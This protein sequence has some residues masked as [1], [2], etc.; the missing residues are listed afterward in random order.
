MVN[1]LD[2]DTAKSQ[3]FL[4]VF[5]WDVQVARYTSYSSVLTVSSVDYTSVPTM[6][7]DFIGFTAQPEADKVKIKI[8]ITFSPIDTLYLGNAHAIVSCEVYEINPEDLTSNRLLIQ[9]KITDL[10]NNIN[11]TV[12]LSEITVSDDIIFADMPLG[13]AANT[14]CSWTFGD[15]NNSPC[16]I[17][18][19]ALRDATTISTIS[20]FV[21][22]TPLTPATSDYYLR[23]YV[24]K[25]S[26][27][28]GIKDATNGDVTLSQSPPASW[29][30]G[31][32]IVLVPGCDKQQTTCINKWNNEIEFMGFGVAMPNYNPLL[33]KGS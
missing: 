6:E 12:G 27:R 21:I 22:T 3:T 8:P 17:D 26:V 2:S 7:L 19:T 1:S 14:T 31:N 29:E 16:G 11:N 5:S 10:I 32:S 25:D 13:I 4:V 18:I 20:G 24:E 15:E 33:E 23:G 28:I 30:A 9:G